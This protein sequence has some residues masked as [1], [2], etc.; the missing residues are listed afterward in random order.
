M[1]ITGVKEVEADEE[2]HLPEKVVVRGAVFDFRGGL[3]PVEFSAVNPKAMDYFIGLDASNA[4]VFGVV[5]YLKLLLE[6]L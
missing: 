5:R 6:K 1:L 2:R 3:L 4:N